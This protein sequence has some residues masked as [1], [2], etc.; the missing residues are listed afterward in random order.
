MDDVAD[1]GEVMVIVH[2][3]DLILECRGA[4]PVGQEGHG[5][6][7][8]RGPGPIGGHIRRDRCGAIQFVSRPFMGSDSHAIML[9]NRD[10][11]VMVKI[12]V[13]RDETRALRADQVARFVALRDR[14][15]MEGETGHDNDA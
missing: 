7:N 11:G 3:A 1:W 14:L 5:Y 13:G 6:F 4:L 9:F 2:T 8:L 10:G 12:F 15:A